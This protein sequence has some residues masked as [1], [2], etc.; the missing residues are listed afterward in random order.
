MKLD[1]IMV[2]VC[3]ITYGHE[4][5]IA[6]TIEGI[7]MQEVDFDFELIISN[8][9]SPDQTDEVVKSYLKDHPKSN[10]VKYFSHKKNMGA[11]QNFVFSLENS[12]GKY[13]ALCEGDDY[14]TDPLKLQKQVDFLESNPD[15]SICFT[16]YA[17]LSENT[18]GL[19]YPNLS[20]KFSVKDSFTKKE[21]ILNNFIP[22][23]TVMFR[24]EIKVLNYLNEKFFPS[25]W[26]LHILNSNYGK[27][28]FLNIESAVYR[29]HD[30]GVCSSAS[31]LLNNKKYLKSIDLF[32]KQFNNDYEMN[33]LF[34]VVK[35]K[36]VIE[37][38][39]IR[40]KLILNKE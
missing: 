3:V 35:A 11:Y 25:D 2:S 9:C 37:S 31:P 27:I 23:L 22:T 14:W 24:K 16:D 30:G 8:D 33:F 34:L 19:T 39:K 17:V 21:I 10:K 26:F 29:I 32:R 7:L 6:Q 13:I 4:K 36:I 15:F 1:N 40:L 18:K 38:L 5:Y 20:K 12:N 28:K